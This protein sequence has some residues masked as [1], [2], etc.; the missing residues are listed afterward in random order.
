M[1]DPTTYFP[2]IFGFLGPLALAQPIVA[3]T[4]DPQASGD[5]VDLLLSVEDHIGWEIDKR[6]TA[7]WHG[8]LGKVR[9]QHRIK[10][11]VLEGLWGGVFLE[12]VLLQRQ[13]RYGVDEE[14]LTHGGST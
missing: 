9:A 12:N 11:G 1:I 6:C 7:R 10:E 8:C 5:D 2:E 3:D 14:L 4:H 13:P